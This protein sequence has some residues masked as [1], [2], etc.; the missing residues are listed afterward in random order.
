MQAGSHTIT[1]GGVAGNCSVSSAGGVTQTVNV[2]YNNTANAAFSVSCQANQ[3]SIKATT[4]TAGTNPD[5]DGYTISV[6]GGTPQAV[7]SNGSRVFPGLSVGNHSVQLTTSTV[8]A[9]CSVTSSNPQTIGVTFGD[10]ATAAFTISCQ[11]NQG[12]IKATT[13][14]AGTNPDADGYTISVD[15]GTPQAVSSNGSRV[16]PGLSVGNHSVQLTTSTVAANCSVTSSNPQT[17][18]VTFGDT[19]TAAFTISCQANQGSIKASNTTTGTDLDSDGYSVSVDGGT[20][21]TMT[22]NGNTTFN[23]VAVGTRSVAIDVSSVQANCSVTSANPTP[24]SVTF[25]DT[26]S[27]SFTISCDPNVGSIQAT[28]TSSG[29]N[30]PSTYTVDYDGTNSTSIDS[31]SSTGV[32]FP[33]VP[34]GSHTVNLTVPGTC[35]VTSAGGAAKPVTVQF[36]QTV[37]AAFTV[38]C[39]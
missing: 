4:S 38:T 24:A 23:N 13:S 8:A 10:T 16:F 9:N 32:T 5:A 31:T 15:G 36:N 11:A 35:T 33:I 28:T 3:G 19:A 20:A 7:S 39:S 34:V 30:I 14:T 6:D 26:A 12:S 22:T 2:T 29:T 25:G 18:G 1:L 17:I 27:A 37:T 21:R